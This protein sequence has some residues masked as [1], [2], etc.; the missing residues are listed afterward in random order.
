MMIPILCCLMAC[1]L[2]FPRAR[3]V[4][5]TAGGNSAVS[6]AFHSSQSHRSAHR[7]PRAECACS[8]PGSSERGDD[9]VE[10][11]RV[12]AGPEDAAFR[13][14]LEHIA[15][16][17]DEPRLDLGGVRHGADRPAAV[18]VLGVEHPDEPGLR[19]EVVQREAHE[20]AHPP[21]RPPLPHSNSPPP[22]GYA[23][24]L[25]QVLLLSPSPSLS[26]K[27]WSARG[28]APARWSPDPSPPRPLPGRN[29]FILRRRDCASAAPPPP[30]PPRAAARRRS[31][32][33]AFFVA[34]V[35]SRPPA[36]PPR[37]AE[38]QR[39]PP[40]CRAA[41]APEASRR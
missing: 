12:D 3:P 15:D 19:D 13:A 26:T 38:Q 11:H 22:F 24:R 5:D 37:H 7:T 28:L 1:P 21:P 9:D 31:V 33:G 4:R 29:S 27:L 39:N 6:S 41:P 17:G 18:E 10:L 23:P 14:A 16:L 40:P 20:I 25:R 35:V 32:G 30:P 36:P 8:T 34:S 2:C